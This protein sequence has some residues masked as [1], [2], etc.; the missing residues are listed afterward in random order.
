MLMVALLL[1]PSFASISRAQ[2][3]SYVTRAEALLRARDWSSL[4]SAAL[5]Q[6]QAHP[7]DASAWGDLARSQFRQGKSESALAS[8]RKAIELD[9][10]HTLPWYIA[11]LI[12][13]GKG[14]R[15][16][17]MACVQGF[18]DNGLTA[19]S[20]FLAEASVAGILMGGREFILFDEANGSAPRGF[21]PP[22]SLGGVN[23]H[24]ALKAGL[25]AHKGATFVLEV[26]LDEAGTPVAGTAL[27]GPEGVR[28]EYLAWALL[29]KFEPATK[30]GVPV[31]SR[32]RLR[33]PRIKSSVTIRT[34]RFR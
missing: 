17:V 34:Q 10:A 24:A 30:G 26:L 8:A 31:A 13:A 9:P 18:R 19:L 5:A 23:M 12:Q 4:E 32:F 2:E 1:T 28:E 15:P 27:E 11:G 16:A 6:V 3:P 25:E 14:D 22:R 21:N 7:E 20:G 33:F 29:W